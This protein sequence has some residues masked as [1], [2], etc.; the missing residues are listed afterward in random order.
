[1]TNTDGLQTLRSIGTFGTESEANHAARIFEEAHPT[2]MVGAVKFHVS[3]LN[4][5]NVK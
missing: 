2:A 1:M 3:E 5:L 4:T